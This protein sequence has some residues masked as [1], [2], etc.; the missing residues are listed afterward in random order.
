M[1][2]NLYKAY[3]LT[4][5]RKAYAATSDILYLLCN[6]HMRMLLEIYHLY[7]LIFNIYLLL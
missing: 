3:A 7:T 1:L 6:L 2:F 5:K 4:R